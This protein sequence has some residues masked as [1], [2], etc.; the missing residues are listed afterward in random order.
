MKRFTL[1]F[2][3]MVV[4][5][6]LF[7]QSPSGSSI[8]ITKKGI[9]SL[10][11]EFYDTT[12]S[13]WGNRLKYEFYY[14]LCG[15]STQFIEYLWDDWTEEWYFGYSEEYY[16]NPASQLAMQKYYE[17]DLT[18][19][20]WIE[21]RK[22]EWYWGTN[23]KVSEKY[24]SQYNLSLNQWVLISKEEFEYDGSGVLEERT[25]YFW[26]D[27]NSIY[28]PGFMDEYVYDPAGNLAMITYYNWNSTTSF[29]DQA[30]RLEQTWSILSHPL[31]STFY[32]YDETVSLFRKQNMMEYI[33]NLNYNIGEV[34]HYT[35]DQST[36]HWIHMYKDLL[37]YDNSY[38]YNTLLLPYI[39]MEERPYHFLHMLTSTIR[40]SFPNGL[41]ADESRESFY[42]SNKTISGIGEAG[43]HPQI[44]LSPNPAT[45]S[46]RIDGLSQQKGYRL[47]FY[48]LTGSKVS[49]SYLT[50]SSVVDV[51][52]WSRGLYL[53]RITLDEEVLKT[54]KV[55]L[56]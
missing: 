50:G 44:T 25:T 47:A 40:Q 20:A 42:Y 21:Q 24:N 53:Y 22:T 23:W 37:S 54:G 45:E 8:N 55:V 11:L 12:T 7:G 48:D 38:P 2:T 15:R 46:I 33:Y 51:S 10:I 19:N 41:W 16:Y 4:A 18:T 9:D 30:A 49:E 5:F 6:G 39:M 29:F 14:D 1:L 28:M 32:I 36:M 35:W 31:T 17:W 27:I 26:D 56:R 3:I 43:S 52:L 34:I 13:V